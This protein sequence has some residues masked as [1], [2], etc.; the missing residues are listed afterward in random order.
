MSIKQKSSFREKNEQGTLYLVPTPIGNLQDMTFR[1]LEILEQ[2]DLICAEDT[3]NTMRLLNHFEIKTPQI[4]FHEHNTQERIPYLI[5][6]LQA[7]QDLAQVSDAG[8]P[9]ISD[10][11]HE[12]VKACIQADIAV[13]PL[14]GANAALSALIASGI[15]PQPFMFYGFLPR[16]KNEQSE[17]LEQLEQ[18]TCAL[19]FYEAPHRL[20]KTLQAMQAVFGPE[21]EIAL[22][23][24]L[25]KRY[26]EFLRGT[27]ADAVEWATNEEI[28]GEFVLVVQG[29]SAPRAKKADPLLELPLAEQVTALIAQKQLKPNAAI[30]EV[31]KLNGLK[32]QDVYNEYHQL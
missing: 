2:V 31:A 15:A 14:P 27:L 29:N 24:E 18:Q 5:E 17:V 19:I 10:P 7:G 9:S 25:T 26:E 8:M 6:K 11:G 22:C 1:A 23:R 28:R 16:K 3:R 12:L 32:K 20:K 21:R 4:S 30:K 13:V